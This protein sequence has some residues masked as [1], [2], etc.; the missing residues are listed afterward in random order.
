MHLSIVTKVTPLFSTFA[1]SGSSKITYW[2]AGL[3]VAFQ[4]KC[5]IETKQE[6]IFI[7]P[8]WT[9][10]CH[11]VI[12]LW[13]FH[14]NHSIYQLFPMATIQWEYILFGIH[15]LN[16]GTP[17]EKKIIVN[18]PTCHVSISFTFLNKAAVETQWSNPNK[19]LYC[20][21]YIVCRSWWDK[22]DIGIRKRINEMLS[23]YLALIWD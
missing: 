4:L 6:D 17:I 8:D 22:S 10:V 14:Q 7:A 20:Q 16:L 5:D 19:H 12:Q 18:N 15:F 21:M 2:S 3:K 13:H 11:H 1:R 9:C 23:A